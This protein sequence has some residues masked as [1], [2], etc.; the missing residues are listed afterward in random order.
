MPLKGCKWANI[1]KNSNVK[2]KLL[3]WPAI[4]PLFPLKRLAEYQS[5]GYNSHWH[6]AVPAEFSLS[7]PEQKL[8]ADAKEAV[9]YGC[10]QSHWLSKIE[11][12]GKTLS[13]AKH[14]FA[15]HDQRYLH[16]YPVKREKERI[17]YYNTE[18]STIIRSWLLV[19]YFPHNKTIYCIIKSQLK[20]GSTITI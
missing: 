4:P 19:T 14:G 17:V 16:I 5:A 13:P 15:Q 9:L 11:A 1:T 12:S 18:M 20:N 6:P 3:H 8:G 2:S 7:E 10:Q